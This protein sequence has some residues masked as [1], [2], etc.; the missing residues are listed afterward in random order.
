[1]KLIM[2]KLP[3]K[4]LSNGSPNNFLIKFH[5]KYIFQAYGAKTS[6]I[7]IRNAYTFLQLYI[8]NK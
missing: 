2:F 3:F 6:G 7:I 4:K 1:M 8:Y 5:Y